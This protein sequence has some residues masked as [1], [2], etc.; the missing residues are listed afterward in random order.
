MVR[1]RRYPR[2]AWSAAGEPSGW[3]ILRQ[4]LRLRVKTCA[5]LREAIVTMATNMR[6]A[7]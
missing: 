6:S 1:H 3:P 4:A 7:E 2:G 5:L